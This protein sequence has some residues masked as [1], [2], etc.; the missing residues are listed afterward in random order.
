[1]KKLYK[2]LLIIIPLL[3]LFGTAPLYADNN[4]N[5]SASDTPVKVSLEQNFPN[6]FNPITS[7]TYTLPES[8]DVRLE[9][10]H[11]LGHRIATLVDGEMEAGTHQ[12]MFDASSLASG[13]Y[14]YRLTTGSQTLVRRMTV[15]K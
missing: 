11:I 3:I 7:I 15:M 2:Q 9:V 13:V 14:I 10:Y 1:M 8:R 6:P 5:E 4:T 12:V